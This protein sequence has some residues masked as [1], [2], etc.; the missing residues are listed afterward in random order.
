M[1]KGKKSLNRG[2]NLHDSVCSLVHS[3][4]DGLEGEEYQNVTITVNVAKNSPAVGK[5]RDGY[6]VSYNVGYV[7]K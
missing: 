2:Y 4:L 6:T 1:A 5:Y 7:I 3:A